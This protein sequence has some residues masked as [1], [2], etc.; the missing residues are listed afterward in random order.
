MNKIL[1]FVGLCLALASA[2]WALPAEE[3]PGDGEKVFSTLAD[4]PFDG[5]IPPTGPDTFQVFAKESGQVQRSY[6]FRVSGEVSLEISDRAG[7]GGF[8]EL[9]GYFEARRTG[10]VLCHFA[11]LVTT[12]E[13]SFNIALAGPEFFSLKKDGIAFWL[14]NRGGKLVH[15]SDSMPKPLFMLQGFTWY[16]VDLRYQPAKGI[17][18]M[19]ISQEG[20]SQPLLELRDQP[21]ATSQPSAVDKF[22]FIGDRGEDTSN[23]VYYVDDLW[24][25]AGE[26]LPLKTFAAPG[27]RQLFVD[28][29][30]KAFS[31]EEAEA[32]RLLRE[33]NALAAR[34]IY[35]EQLIAGRDGEGVNLFLKLA[36]AYWLLGDLDEERKIRER[37]YGFL[38]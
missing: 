19:T 2:M 6:Y 18:D 33:G 5:E 31:A 28:M 16:F 37:F 7:D 10:E 13:E 17:Y 15:W 25:A 4:Y 12:L 26:K 29:I 20:L 21:N 9:Q 32:D 3:A 22:S 14:E 27:R 1:T 11:F 34:D 30:G 8:P 38:P 35:L 36:D 24:I 23:V